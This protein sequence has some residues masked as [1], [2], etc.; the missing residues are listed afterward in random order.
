MLEKKFTVRHMLWQKTSHW[1]IFPHQTNEGVPMIVSI[2]RLVCDDNSLHVLRCTVL[3]E[4]M[5]LSNDNFILLPCFLEE[6]LFSCVLQL[7]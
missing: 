7:N 5:N 2:L 4:N 1:D 6:F 3:F